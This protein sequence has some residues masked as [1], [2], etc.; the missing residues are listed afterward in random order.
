MEVGAIEKGAVTVNLFVNQDTCRECLLPA[1]QLETLFRQALLEN[2]M[3]WEV[4]VV[5]I[6]ESKS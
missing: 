3:S 1:P 2:G 4:R 5:F 6:E